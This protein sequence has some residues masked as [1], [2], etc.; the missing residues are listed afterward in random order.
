[1]CEGG[2]KF[3]V[4]RCE[5]YSDAREVFGEFKYNIC[6]FEEGISKMMRNLFSCSKLAIGVGILGLFFS[7]CRMQTETP[8][9]GVSSQSS[10][11]KEI[12]VVVK[13]IR[14]EFKGERAIGKDSQICWAL[15]AGPEGFPS[16]SSKVVKSACQDVDS[17]VAVFR[18]RDLPPSEQGY[19]VSIFQD[20]NKNGKLDT[21]GLF[22]MQVPTEP[23]GF[24]QNPSLLGAP[25]FDKCK[26]LP[27]VNEQ[28]YVI[29]MKT[30]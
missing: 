15:F 2:Q 25:T 17:T 3:V 13:K 12:K 20:M 21:R 10:P 27:T 23:F 8:S 18:V 30:I 16:D 24:T 1:M 28:E 11:V 9:S 19:V 6:R 14:Y 22:G 5:G 4:E 29:E 7:G 26:I